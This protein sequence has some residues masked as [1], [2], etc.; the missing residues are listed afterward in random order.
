MYSSTGPHT[1]APRR[2]VPTLSPFLSRHYPADPYP[3]E[4]PDVSYV[5]LDG[6]A[7]ILRPDRGAASGWVVD[8][9]T[10]VGTDLDTWLGALGQPP[11]DARLPVLAYGSNAC[12]GKIEWIRETLGL[13]GPAVVQ[14]VEVAGVAAVWSAGTRARDGQ[15]PAVLAARPGTT[16]RHALWWVTPRQRATLDEVEARGECYRLGWVH[17]PATTD[18]GTKR[19]RVL[20][21]VARPEVLGTAVAD[22]LDRSPML[23]DGEPVRVADVGQAD[24][25]RM[26]GGRAR[27]DGL[28]VLE[29]TGEPS[30]SDLD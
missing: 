9:G 15:R 25:L 29:V 27:S 17:A 3:G 20:A 4:R 5:E 11:L 18:D 6:A 7:W 8:T 13:A 16:E 22:H 2:A 30:W 28:D 14:T 19:D 26:R 1:D 21:Y 10:S 12:P 24:I 23:V